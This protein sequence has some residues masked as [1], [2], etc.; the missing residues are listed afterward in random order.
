MTGGLIGAWE[1]AALAAFDVELTTSRGG[2]VLLALAAFALAGA[3]AL[4]AGLVFALARRTRPG[5]FIL[6][7]RTAGVTFA[8]AAA[9]LFYGGYYLNANVLP[10]KL[11]PASLAADAALLAVCWLLVRFAPPIKIGR[12]GL[13]AAFA[14]LLAGA[15]VISVAA[16]GSSLRLGARASTMPGR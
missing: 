15:V 12:R 16:A 14:L 6:G 1:A 4:L 9:L 2:V 8:V 3:A 5:R 13:A 11:H 10:A 7:E